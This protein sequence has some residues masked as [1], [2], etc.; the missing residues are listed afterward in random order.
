MYL[1]SFANFKKDPPWYIFFLSVHAPATSGGLVSAMESI[2]KNSSHLKALADVAGTRDEVRDGFVGG[3]GDLRLFG[4]LLSG[5]FINDASKHLF[6]FVTCIRNRLFYCSLTKWMRCTL[7]Y[8][9]L[10][11]FISILA[12]VLNFY[13]SDQNLHFW[14]QS[15]GLEI[16]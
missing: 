12:R 7:S 4:V 1:L 5:K 15:W 6:W 14:W 8:P 11:L 2:M 10:N 16:A 9:H 13:K 3:W